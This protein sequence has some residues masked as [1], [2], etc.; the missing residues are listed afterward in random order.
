MNYN[1]EGI[2]ECRL[3]NANEF[4]SAMINGMYILKQKLI[5]ANKLY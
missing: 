5:P 3:P 1:S 2:P 4:L